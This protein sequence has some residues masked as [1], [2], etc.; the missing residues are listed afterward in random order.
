[1]LLHLRCACSALVPTVPHFSHTPKQSSYLSLYKL[2]MIC[3][4][5]HQTCT[6]AFTK[7]YLHIQP[8]ANVRDKVPL[9]EE[10]DQEEEDGADSV[11][12]LNIPYI[13][14]ANRLAC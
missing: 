12:V 10:E 11:S 14:S 6:Y 2:D 7:I 4:Y 1:M 8:M 5:T 3:M 13:S 9:E